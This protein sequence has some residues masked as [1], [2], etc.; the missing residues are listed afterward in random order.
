MD[1]AYKS[2]VQISAYRIRGLEVPG[3]L[4]LPDDAYPPYRDAAASDSTKSAAAKA[5]K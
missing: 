1:A 4:E 3:M 5:S 2:N